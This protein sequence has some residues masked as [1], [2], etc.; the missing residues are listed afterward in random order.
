M[1]EKL[2]QYKDLRDKA[3]TIQSK[4]RE[5][6]VHASSDNGHVQVVMDGNQQLIGIEIDPDSLRTEGREQLQKHIISAVNDAVKK[7]QTEMAQTLKNTP[8]LNLPSIT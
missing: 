3:K 1:F 5:V 2:K 8:G 4:L 7:S 6:T